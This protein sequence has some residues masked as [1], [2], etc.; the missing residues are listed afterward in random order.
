MLLFIFLFQ[1][2]ISCYFFQSNELWMKKKCKKLCRKVSKTFLGE[3][4]R[5]GRV[6][7]QS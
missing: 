5:P 1:F 7:L 2:Y 4:N 3:K 6:P